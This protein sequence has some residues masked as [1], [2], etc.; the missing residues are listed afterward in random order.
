RRG[1]FLVATLFSDR[2]CRDNTVPVG[3]TYLLDSPFGIRPSL[4]GTDDGI[5]L[6]GEA[7]FGQLLK[8][9]GEVGL[10]STTPVT[11][12]SGRVGHL[13][14]VYQDAV[15]RFSFSQ[16]LEFIGDALA[17]WHPPQTTWKDR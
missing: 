16:E 14:E 13:G 9:A 2:L 4:L 10:P 3:G 6:R 5:E 17:Y 11:T 15:M 1:D 12:A 8:L 7:H